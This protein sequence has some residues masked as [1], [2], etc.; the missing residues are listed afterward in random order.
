[1][2]TKQRLT[3]AQAASALGISIDATRMRVRRGKLPSERDEDGVR[4]LL[5]ADQVRPDPDETNLTDQLRSE[6]AYLREENQRKDHLLAALIQKVPALEPPSD[7]R[8]DVNASREET[9]GAYSGTGSRE[10][11]EKPASWWKRFV[12]R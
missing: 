10:D 9:T 6:V 11:S 12:G 3:Y 8:R 1:M 2:G 4:V 5:D 7:E